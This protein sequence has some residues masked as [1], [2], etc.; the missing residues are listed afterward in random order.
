MGEGKAG[1]ES[2]F[3]GCAQGLASFCSPKVL[4]SENPSPCSSLPLWNEEPG[5]QG[6]N[7]SPVPLP[8]TS[9]AA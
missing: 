5:S 8:L 1:G 3:F 6:G 9:W 4:R 7:H 2:G